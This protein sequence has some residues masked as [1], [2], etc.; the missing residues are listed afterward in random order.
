MALKKVAKPKVQELKAELNAYLVPLQSERVFRLSKAV[1]WYNGAIPYI[2]A[3]KLV[4]SQLDVKRLYELAIKCQE[5][6]AGTNFPHEAETALKMALRKFQEICQKFPGLP[7][8]NVFENKLDAMMPKIMEKQA[9]LEA[10]YRDG[11]QL[12]QNAFGLPLKATYCADCK[13]YFQENPEPCEKA[14]HGISI[15][16]SLLTKLVVGTQPQTHQLSPAENTLFLG[17]TVMVR[18][19]KAVKQE[20]PLVGLLTELPAIASLSAYIPVMDNG[21]LK[22]QRDSDLM[23]AFYENLMGN[24]TMWLKNGIDPR[25]LVRKNRPVAA[26]IAA[27]IAAASQPQAPAIP[28]VVIPR[29]VVP[30]PAGAFVPV[31]GEPMPWG[32]T[33]RI[34]PLFSVLLKGVPETD[35]DALIVSMGLLPKAARYRL[36]RDGRDGIRGLN[37]KLETS[38][39]ITKVVMK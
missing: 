7:D 10:L 12:M 22:Y 26:P 6:A 4:P 11:I 9:K 16:Q 23:Q 25:R 37:W 36:F 15:K 29:A 18:L 39:G 24:L 27:P 8:I 21:V 33:T 2:L 35:L 32:A 14:G 19:T 17:K 1:I 31:A 30:P 3:H 28:K 13:K 20:G 34:A 38:N 5:R